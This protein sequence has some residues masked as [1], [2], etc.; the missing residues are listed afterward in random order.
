MTAALEAAECG[1]NVVLVEKNPALGGRVSSF[2]AI[3]QAVPSDLRS[4]NQLAP[5]Q[6][7]S[8]HPCADDG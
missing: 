5:T 1:K 2:I 6:A 7:E 8:A 4:G 3:S